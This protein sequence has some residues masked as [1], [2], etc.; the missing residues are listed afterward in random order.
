MQVHKRN[1]YDD[2]DYMGV[3]S[4]PNN[5]HKSH[6]R[7][8]SQDK[9]KGMTTPQKSKHRG[10]WITE[11][12]EEDSFRKSSKKRRSPATPSYS[13]H[14]VSNS[15][16]HCQTYA[17]P[18]GGGHKSPRAQIYNHQ[19]YSADQ[20]HRSRSSF[21]PHMSQYG[22]SSSQGSE[23]AAESRYSGSRFGNS[24]SDYSRR[25]YGW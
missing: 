9:D 21:K 5:L 2:E 19:Q 8:K 4:A 1:R 12:P 22:A 7:K 10:G 16:S 18:Y 13:R 24:R 17:S 15:A 3:K 6:K 11:D 14:R 20:G 23:N 25:D